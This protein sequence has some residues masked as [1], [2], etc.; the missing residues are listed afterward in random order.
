VPAI[1]SARGRTPSHYIQTWA[2]DF[3]ASCTLRAMEEIAAAIEN[4]DSHG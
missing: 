2:A 4:K 3:A 1:R